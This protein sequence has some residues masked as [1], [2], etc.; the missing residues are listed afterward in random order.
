MENYGVVQAWGDGPGRLHQLGMLGETEVHGS[1]G[2]ESPVT[3][4]GTKDWEEFSLTLRIR[5][6]RPLQ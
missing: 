2:S 6:N 4:C 5:Q 1:G 3:S